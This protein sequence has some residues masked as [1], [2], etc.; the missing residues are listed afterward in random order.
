MKRFLPLIFALLL[1]FPLLLVPALAAPASIVIDGS[2][3]DNAI[4][5]F[6]VSGVPPGHYLLSLSAPLAGEIAYTPDPMFFSGADSSFDIYACSDHLGACIGLPSSVVSGQLFVS[7]V[8]GLQPGIPLTL[9]FVPAAESSLFSDF[10]A[11]ASAVIDWVGQIATAIV[12]HPL[13]LVTV[14]IFFAG[15][16]IAL[17]SRFLSR[18]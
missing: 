11:V 17:F 5:S 14:G 10:S 9:T 8:M 18:D 1:V 12:E 7:N 15:G 3:V 16:C 4:C 13:L 2:V 6:D